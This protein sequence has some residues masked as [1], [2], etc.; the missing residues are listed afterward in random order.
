MQQLPCP[1]IERSILRICLQGQVKTLKG[2]ITW[3][4]DS[5]ALKTKVK[6]KLRGDTLMSDLKGGLHFFKISFSSFIISSK[7]SWGVEPG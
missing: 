6:I 2:H 7:S 4:S 3:E 5:I 1:L